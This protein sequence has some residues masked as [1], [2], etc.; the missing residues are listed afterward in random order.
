MRRDVIIGVGWLV[1]VASAAGIGMATISALGSGTSGPSSR[2]VS[3]AEVDRQLAELAASSQAPSGVPTPSE[4]ATLAPSAT[5]TDTPTQEVFT[6]RGGTVVARCVGS[7]VQLVSW[8]PA[9]GFH[10]DGQ[11]VRGPGPT[12]SVKFSARH[13]NDYTVEVTCRD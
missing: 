8:S 9:Q 4:S 1:A 10:V 7:T 12:A 5:E 6:T 13:S 3:A 11:V 2:P